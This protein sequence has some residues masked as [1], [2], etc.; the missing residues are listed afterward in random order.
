MN[1]D[2]VLRRGAESASDVTR[3]LTAKAR[4]LLAELEKR[5][6]VEDKRADVARLRDELAAAK[7]AVRRPQRPMTTAIR[8]ECVRLYVEEELTVAEVGGRV[9]RPWSSVRRALISAGVEMRSAG[10]PSTRAGGL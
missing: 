8:A 2:E 4:G 10:W 9:D 1:A 6:V 5:L 3:R 7:N